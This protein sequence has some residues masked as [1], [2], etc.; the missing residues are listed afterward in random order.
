MPTRLRVTT[1]QLREGDIVR[2]YGMRVRLDELTTFTNQGRTVYSWRGTVLNLDEVLAEGRVSARFLAEHD[3]VPGKGWV[4]VRND[5][6]TIQ[7]NAQ[8]SWYVEREG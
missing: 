1:D 8:V 2:E 6:W 3:W 4:K 5:A 7:G